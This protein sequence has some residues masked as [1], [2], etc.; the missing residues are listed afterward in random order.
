MMIST[1]EYM[2]RAF[3]MDAKADCSTEEP[4]IALYRELAQQWRTLYDLAVWRDF[5]T[6]P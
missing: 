3:A 2:A 5:E 4:A 1:D 6:H